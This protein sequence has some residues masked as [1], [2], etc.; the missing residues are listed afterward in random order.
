MGLSWSIRLQRRR[1][2]ESNFVLFHFL[3]RQLCSQS[4]H[5]CQRVRRQF[6]Q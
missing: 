3:Q 1:L 4:L 6:L 5:Y 2:M